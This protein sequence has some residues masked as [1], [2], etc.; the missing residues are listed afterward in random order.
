MDLTDEEKKIVEETQAAFEK[1][2]ATAFPYGDRD[3]RGK[4][5]YLY[6][7]LHL[8]FLEGKRFGFKRGIGI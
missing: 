7:Y 3:W 5:S 1:F 6:D 4:D 2:L 8:A